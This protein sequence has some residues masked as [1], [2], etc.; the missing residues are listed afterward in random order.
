ML[1]FNLRQGDSSPTLPWHVQMSSANTRNAPKDPFGAFLSF[2]ETFLDTHDKTIVGSFIHNWPR[3]NSLNILQVRRKRQR[4]CLD[5]WIR[6]RSNIG[7]KGRNRVLDCA[8]FAFFLKTGGCAQTRFKQYSTPQNARTRKHRFLFVL[9]DNSPHPTVS[10]LS[11]SSPSLPPSLF[12]SSYAHTRTHAIIQ[13][14]T[15]TLQTTR[16][17]C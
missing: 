17:P 16:T 13:L 9:C 12:L 10:Y 6:M 7:E 15:R 4:F 5:R 1:A 11:S 8:P 14:A 3:C 2:S